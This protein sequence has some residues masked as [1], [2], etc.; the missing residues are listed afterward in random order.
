MLTYYCTKIELSDGLENSQLSN[1]YI[2]Q[3]RTIKHTPN[4]GRVER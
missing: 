1:L 2:H 4:T 3:Y